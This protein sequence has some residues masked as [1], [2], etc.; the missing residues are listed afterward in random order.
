M[1]EESEARFG[2]GVLR[3]TGRAFALVWRTHRG[4]SVALAALS[5]VAGVVP[6]GIAY[7]GK[8]IVDG[9]ILAA[10]SGADADRVAVLWFI[11]VE[12]ALVAR[13]ARPRAARSRW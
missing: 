8:L 3:Y 1:E 11:G 6:A 10:E 7:V 12:L 4:L 2:L 5:L 13:G 9:V